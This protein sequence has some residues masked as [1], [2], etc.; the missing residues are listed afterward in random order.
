MKIFWRPKEASKPFFNKKHNTK[1]QHFLGISSQTLAT[2]NQ[3]LANKYFAFL[4]NCGSNIA[5]LEPNPCAGMARSLPRYPY[6]R[7]LLREKPL[8]AGPTRAK[9][10]LIRGPG[11]G[12]GRCSAKA[13]TPEAPAPLTPYLAALAASQGFVRTAS[14]PQ[15]T[16]S[17]PGE[18]EDSVPRSDTSSEEPECVKPTR[19]PHYTDL[20]TRQKTAA[21][22][23]RS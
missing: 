3:V 16:A 4:K 19:E 5:I 2:A 12:R 20:L 18:K 10:R 22:W 14:G 1:C 7:T 21:R 17:I 6:P 8:E 23:L 9:T 11:R 15:I 13:P